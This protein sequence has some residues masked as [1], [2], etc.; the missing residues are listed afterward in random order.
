MR[1]FLCDMRSIGLMDIAKGAVI[2]VAI[3]LAVPAMQVALYVLM[4][5][6]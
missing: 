5:L 1:Q 3:A 6:P 2:V 4:D